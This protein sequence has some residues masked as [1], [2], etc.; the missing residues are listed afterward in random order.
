MES[1]S[2]SLSE[3]YELDLTEDRSLTINAIR[4]FMLK[5][6]MSIRDLSRLEKTDV[7]DS[8]RK[9]FAQKE[10]PAFAQRVREQLQGS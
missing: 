4:N 10:I 8:M 1:K 2:T 3:F 7:E 5:G 6:G 9:Y